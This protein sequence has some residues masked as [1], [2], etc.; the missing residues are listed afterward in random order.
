MK[1][2]LYILFFPIII[3]LKI[4]KFI[5]YAIAIDSI[6]DRDCLSFKT[7]KIPERNYG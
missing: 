7:S 3:P 2:I 5:L 1:A 4:I 6:F